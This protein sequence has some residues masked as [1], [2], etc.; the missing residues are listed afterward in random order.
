M[1]TVLFDKYVASTVP[2]FWHIKWLKPRD[3]KCKTCPSQT[4]R[5]HDLSCSWA[6][7]PFPEFTRL[8]NYGGLNA[9]YAWPVV[10]RCFLKARDGFLKAENPGLKVR[11]KVKRLLLQHWL[12]EDGFLLLSWLLIHHAVS[13][14][15]SSVRSRAGWPAQ[16]SHILGFLYA[17]LDGTAT[18]TFRY[19]RQL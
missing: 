11:Y 10:H 6:A 2:G 9:I 15:S 13:F 8:A 7:K 18:K 12:S 3:L 1:A 17:H 19:Q 16:S 4:E 5:Y 14:D